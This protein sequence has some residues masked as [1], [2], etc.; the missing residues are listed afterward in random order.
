MC[1]LCGASASRDY[2]GI[3]LGFKYIPGSYLLNELGLQI[4]I[5]SVQT[6]LV[7]V[8]DGLQEFME[9]HIDFELCTL[10]QSGLIGYR[11]L[12]ENGKK[13]LEDEGLRALVGVVRETTP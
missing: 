3:R 4:L 8:R 11:N 9:E 10:K 7:D 5:T 13:T 1:A 6:A 12:G 2:S